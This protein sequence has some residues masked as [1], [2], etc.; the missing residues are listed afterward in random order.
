MS[1]EPVGSEESVDPLV[2]EHRKQ[3]RDTEEWHRRVREWQETVDQPLDRLLPVWTAAWKDLTETWRLC[4]GDENSIE[5]LSE[6]LIRVAD[7]IRVLEAIRVTGSRWRV[8][9]SF[10]HH[11]VS[12]VRL[13]WC[14]NPQKLT[15][16][17]HIGD[18]YGFQLP[19]SFHVACRILDLSL[20]VP[21]SELTRKIRDM[22]EIPESRDSAVWLPFLGS[23]LLPLNS[24]GYTLRSYK[25]EDEATEIQ[26]A[27]DGVKLPEPSN[28][29]TKVEIMQAVR[30][31]LW[32][33]G[34]MDSTG[35]DK[36]RSRLLERVDPVN[37]MSVICR[38]NRSNAR[39]K[40]VENEP[41]DAGITGASQTSSDG[42]VSLLR[43]FTDGVI[44]QRF[45]QAAEIIKDAR[46][47]A[48]D[49]LFKIDA[50]IRIPANASAQKLADMLNLKKQAILQTNW[51]AQYRKGEKQNE[52]GRRKAKLIEKGECTEFND[53][54]DDQ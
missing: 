26:L 54:E 19:R 27:V 3:K 11:G 31:G 42:L 10:G 18:P 28:S 15:E 30:Y 45:Q 32:A 4:W 48:N 46:M 20:T 5:I 35:Y 2:A 47:T 7:Q 51:W 23:I 12:L 50:L 16:G 25:H 34:R 13:D 22:K 24:S 53:H 8:S 6:K 29:L 36:I 1:S 49:K 41:V 43:V 14:R 38:S 40:Q 17:F 33:I 44:D 9:G 39:E 52:I 37:H 21:K